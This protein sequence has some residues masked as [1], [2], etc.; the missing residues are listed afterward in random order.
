M[1]GNGLLITPL[2][3]PNSPEK[4]QKSLREMVHNIDNER[5]MQTYLKGHVSKVPSK[6]AQIKYEQHPVSTS[7]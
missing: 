7:E 3:D 4:G 5:D 1:L 6:S 2:G